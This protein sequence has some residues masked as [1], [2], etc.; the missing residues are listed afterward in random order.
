MTDNVNPGANRDFTD[1]IVTLDTRSSQSSHV[2]NAPENEP[3]YLFNIENKVHRIVDNTKPNDPAAYITPYK[4]KLKPIQIKGFKI[5]HLN[6]RSIL[7]KIDDIRILMKE[8]NIDVIAFTETWL[9]EGVTDDLIQIDGYKIYRNDRSHGNGGGVAIYVKDTLQHCLLKDLNS[10]KIENIWV[11][12][13]PDYQKEYLIACIYRPP[14]APN[15]YLEDIVDCVEHAH[16]ISNNII[17]LG[18]L[19][20]NFQIDQI[21]ATDPCVYLQNILGTR[22]LIT[23]PTRVTL[24]SSTIID[25]IYTTIPDKHVKSGVID[26]CMSDH[27]LIYTILGCK[28]ASKQPKDIL[29]RSYNKFNLRSFINDISSCTN[30]N[31][32]NINDI[33]T[34]WNKWSSSFANICERH[35]PLRTIRVKDRNKPWV[36]KEILKLIYAR[37]IAHKIALRDQNENKWNE[38]RYLRNLIVN[39]LRDSEKKFLTNELRKHKGKSSMWKPLKMAMNSNNKSSSLPPSL[40]PNKLNEYYVHMGTKLAEKFE[41]EGDLSGIKQHNENFYFKP[42]EVNTIFKKLMKLDSKSKL[43]ILKFDGRLLQCAAIH[44][45]P[46]ITHICNLSMKQGILPHAWKQARVTPIYKGKGDA[47]DCANYRPISTLPFI[48]KIIEACVQE[49][50]VNYLNTNNMLCCE[51]SAYLKHHST[52]TSLHNVVDEWLTNINDGLINGAAFFDLSKCFDTINHRRLIQKLEKYGIRNTPLNWF[53]NYLSCRSQAVRVNN[54]LSDFLDILMGVPQGSNLGP[55][56]FLLFVNDFPSCLQCS[57]CNLFADDTAIYCKAKTIDKLNTDLQLET[58]QAF[59][60][61]ND[62]L[63]TVNTDKTCTI[64]I[65]TRQRITPTDDL[66]ITLSN[67]PLNPVNRIKYLGVTIDK[68]L[69][70]ND[71]INNLVSKVSP[72]IALLRKLKYKLSTEHLNT[73]YLSIIQPHFDYCI[74]VWGHTSQ[75]NIHLIQRLQNRAARTITGKYDWNISVTKLIEE[76]GWMNISQ[77]IQYFTSLLTYKASNGKAPSYISEK[78]KIKS[79]RYE[80]RETT[81]KNFIIPKPNLEIFRHSFS[82]IAPKMFNSLPQEV[83]TSLTI[84]SFKKNIKHHLNGNQQ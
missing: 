23:K 54:T 30:L 44:I 69:T 31:V 32:S 73:V 63:L 78:L 70:W 37:D 60:W 18:D 36:T 27:F 66:T 48:A 59:K 50:L 13:T 17:F 1:S 11:K 62:N 5:C 29:I 47:N 10:D 14:S 21:N 84:E 15:Q 20:Y 61:F 46:Q 45:A 67:N 56:L 9:S 83:K 72:K 82:Y 52:N 68:N 57:S 25:H 79:S 40:T 81:N 65:G 4:H 71:H 24:K 55:L 6:I 3:I 43:D 35:A 39:K 26:L 49:Q 28:S 77:R 16:S 33:N 74:S 34:A 19:N 58:N 51:Q 76:L 64:V 12:I 41:T 8:S 38:Y 7:P 22:Q 42:L 2:N 80:T 53:T 75:R